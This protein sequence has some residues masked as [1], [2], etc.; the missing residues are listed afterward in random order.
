MRQSLSVAD[1][2]QARTGLLVSLLLCLAL[3]AQKAT[4]PPQARN[5]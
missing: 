3:P 4:F 1:H 5:I 2:G